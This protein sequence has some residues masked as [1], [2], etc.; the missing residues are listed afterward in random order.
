MSSFKKLL[1]SIITAFLILLV[2]CTETPNKEHL[3]KTIDLTKTPLF[4]YAYLSSIYESPV[5]FVETWNR[6]ALKKAGIKRI[7][8]FSKG[9]ENPDDTLNEITYRYSNNWKTLNYTSITHESTV[10][11]KSTGTLTISN[12]SS[13]ET[14]L[15]TQLFGIKKQLKT[16]VKPIKAGF[17][18]LHAKR[19][20]SYD[21][22]WVIGSFSQPEAIVHKI[23]NSIFSVE[24]F[25]PDGSSKSEI[26]QHYERLPMVDSQLGVTQFIVTFTAN[27]RPQRS[28]LLDERFSQIIKV[29]EWTY[30]KNHAI[31]TYREWT[32]NTITQDMQWYYGESQ[33]PDYATFNRNT[34]FYSYE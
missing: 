5:S 6:E 29:R 2:S 21:S 10:K 26:I 4:H 11:L 17:L 18:L 28:F 32:G 33:L 3:F 15:F 20:T 34:Y 25:L 23:G 31:A 14:I 8:L 9:G 27:R 22:T 13:E 16:T 30:N 19:N 1:S 12:K 24:L 7:L